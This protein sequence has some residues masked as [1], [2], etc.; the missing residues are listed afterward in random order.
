MDYP[1]N[2]LSDNSGH[3]I[4]ELQ[5]SGHKLG[6]S[7]NNVNIFSSTC[8]GELLVEIEAAPSAD[9]MDEISDFK[10]LPRATGTKSSKHNEN[11]IENNC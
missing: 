11:W 8:S 7:M 10:N 6:C 2:V 4:S 3:L 5:I 9:D 1:Y